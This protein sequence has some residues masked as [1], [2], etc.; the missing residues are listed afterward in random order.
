MKTGANLS[1]QLLLLAG[2]LLLTGLLW[3]ANR[4]WTEQH[5]DDTEDELLD[6]HQDA[7]RPPAES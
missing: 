1:D 2:L 5:Q 3:L 7:K 4:W 6:N